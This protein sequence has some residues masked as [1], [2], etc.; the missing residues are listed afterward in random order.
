MASGFWARM[1][2][3]IFLLGGPPDELR[4]HVRRH[5]DVEDLDRPVGEQVVDGRVDGR[6]VMALRDLAGV[7]RRC[8]RRWRPG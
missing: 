5:G 6:D 3:T 1:P 4:L 7:V 2:R 8:G